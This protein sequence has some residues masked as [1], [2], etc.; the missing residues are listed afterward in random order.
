MSPARLIA[1]TAALLAALAAAGPVLA[2]TDARAR[3]DTG[4]ARAES[5]AA[6]M[7]VDRDGKIALDEADAFAQR[8]FTSM[9]VDASGDLT[10]SEMRGWEF[11]MADIAAFRDRTQAYDTAIGIAFDVLDDDRDGRVTAAE[12][13]DGIARSIAASDA[14]GDGGVSR[15]EFLQRFVYSVAMRNALEDRP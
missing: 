1:P 9:D 14:D 10:L 13:S 3:P 5:I 7:D 15:T 11:G 6:E 12:H 8:I 2:Q 4:I